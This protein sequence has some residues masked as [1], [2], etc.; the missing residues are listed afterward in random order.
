MLPSEEIVRRLRIV[1]RS[2][3]ADRAAARIT[4]MNAISKA[5]GICRMHLYR[6]ANG[7]LPGPRARSELSRVFGCNDLEGVRS[8]GRPPSTSLAQRDNRTAPPVSLT[9]G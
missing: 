7:E 8:S 6:I 9:R 4:T 2:S 5:S 1:R 3:K